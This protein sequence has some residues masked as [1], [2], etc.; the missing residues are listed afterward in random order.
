LE[1]QLLKRLEVDCLVHHDKK[2]DP[3]PSKKQHA[4]NKEAPAMIAACTRLEA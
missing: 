2:G 1:E 3:V 4:F